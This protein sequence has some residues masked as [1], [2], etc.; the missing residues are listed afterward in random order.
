MFKAH[1]ITKEHLIG[2]QVP[3]L[4]E[5]YKPAD[6][7]EL[8]RI[9]ESY[10]LDNPKYY[11]NN[12]GLASKIIYNFPLEDEELQG[13]VQITNSYDK[14]RAFRLRIGCKVKVCSNGMF[15]SYG[16]SEFYGKHYNTKEFNPYTELKLRL[17]SLKS[18]GENFVK[19]KNKLKLAPFTKEE[20][21]LDLLDCVL[22]N[23]M[24]LTVSAYSEIN[25]Q[26]DNPRFNYHNGE[27]KWDY[28]NHFT[29]I[30]KE[31]TLFGVD[32][33]HDKLINHFEL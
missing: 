14:T 32:T 5:S 27:T 31:H 24:R 17:D 23:K 7:K 25:N 33:V 13:I 11:S 30:L 16:D 18:F 29:Y 15:T 22:K 28:Y 2:L 4:T 10:N 6:Y 21:K 9:G 1:R 20:M 8:I 3:D 26:I 19:V 12:N